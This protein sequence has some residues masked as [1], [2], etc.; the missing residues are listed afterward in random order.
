MFQ[1]SGYWS[2]ATQH[3]ADESLSDSILWVAP[4][5]KLSIKAM[6]HVTK[7]LSG[8]QRRQFLFGI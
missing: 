3:L 1:C 2:L 6:K 8:L 4:I 7:L 5:I